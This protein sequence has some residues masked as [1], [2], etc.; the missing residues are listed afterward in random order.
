MSVELMSVEQMPLEQKSVEQM[1][2]EQMSLE[3]MSLEAMFLELPTISFFELHKDL[4]FYF[5]YY[6]PAMLALFVMS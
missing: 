4:L 5:K 3:Q 1:S 2:L 6:W